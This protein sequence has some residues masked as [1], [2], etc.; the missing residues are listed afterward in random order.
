MRF[1]EP[2]YGRLPAEQ[3]AI[4]AQCFHPSGTFVEFP[5][6][7]IHQSISQR[8]E[9]VVQ[10]YPDRL[11]VKDRGRELSYDQLNQAANRLAHTILAVRAST[12]EPIGLLFNKGV[13]LI[14]AMLGALKGNRGYVLL[15]SSLPYERIKF[16]LEHSR[17][18]TLLIDSEHLALSMKLSEERLQCINVDEIDSSV[19]TE[20]LH[21]RVPPDAI[22]WIH[23]TSGSTGEPKGVTQNH[24]NALHTVMTHTNNYHV[25]SDDRLTFFDSRGGS[26]LVALLNGAAV[27]PYDIKKQGLAGLA[28]WLIREEITVY[29]SVVSTFRYFT[30]ALSGTDDFVKLRLI[31]LFGEPLYKSDVEIYH[32]HFSKRCVL[33][34]RLASNESPTICQYFIDHSTSLTGGLVPVGYTTEDNDISLLDET[35][36]QVGSGE[37]GEIAVKSSFLSLGYWREPDLTRC[38]FLLPQDEKD[39]RIYRTGDLARRFEDGCLVHVG[40]KDFGVKIRGNKVELPEIETALLEFPNSKEAVV[41]AIKDLGGDTKLVAYVVPRNPPVPTVDEFRSFLANKMPDYMIPSI[42]ITMEKLPKTGIGKVDRRALPE[43]RNHRP[44]LRAPFVKPESPLETTLAQIWAEVLLLDEV[45]IRDDFFDLG[46]HSLAASR[47]VSRVI[48]AFEVVIPLSDLF[49]CPT[50]QQMATVVAQNQ[51]DKTSA[52]QLARLLTEVEILSDD[53]ANRILTELV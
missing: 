19:S 13:N 20:N 8:F 42:F 50:V 38:A 17:V 18:A 52:D 30:S 9:K 24:R 10:S 22:A 49:K 4:R 12:S 45:G 3:Q 15:D 16:I 48:Q 43:P 39:K 40:R 7:D 1:D 37:V 46:G 44:N 35:G 14:V 5:R 21:L 28:E 11:A 36:K 41:T 6:D 31:R 34:N 53:A 47:V 51:T 29:G 33:E 23:Y 32:K 2:K 27:Y 26:A 25:C